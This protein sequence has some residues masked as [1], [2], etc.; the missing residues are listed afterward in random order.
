M[1]NAALWALTLT[2]AALLSLS[3]LSCA[4][5]KVDPAPSAGTSG[6]V[7]QKVCP[8]SGDPADKDIYVDYKGK[9]VYLCCSDCVT[10]FKK[11][12]DKYMK[13]LEEQQQAAGKQAQPQ[14]DAPAAMPHH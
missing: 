14:H 7:E 2:V 8:V 10:E 9:R 6:V 3:C 12:P 11:D 1:R 4:R 5:N 13:K